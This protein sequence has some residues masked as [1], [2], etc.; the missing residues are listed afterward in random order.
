MF[1]QADFY[2]R[3]QPGSGQVLWDLSIC[4]STLEFKYEATCP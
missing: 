1:W 3:S 4:N 2:R